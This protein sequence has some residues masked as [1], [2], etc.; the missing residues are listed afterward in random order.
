MSSLVEEQQRALNMIAAG[1]WEGARPILVKLC[2][3]YPE[4]ASLQYRTACAHDTLGL[5]KE[6]VPFY[7]A[8]IRLGLAGEELQGAYVGLGSTYRLLGEFA[9]SI[10]VLLAGSQKFPNSQVLKI[11]EAMTL[12]ESGRHNLAVAMLLHCVADKPG[13]HTVALYRR[14]I[15]QYGAE[16]G[17]VSEQCAGL[18]SNS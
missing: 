16:F 17:T 18:K 15:Q 13:D 4:D 11:F 2:Q 10:E 8:A 12:H 14:A 3:E 7:E 6:A 1:D 9:K 5:E